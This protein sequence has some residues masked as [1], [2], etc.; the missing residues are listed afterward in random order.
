MKLFVQCYDE[1]YEL[2]VFLQYTV[3]HVKNMLRENEPNIDIMN[4]YLNEFK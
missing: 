3:E 2:E 4:L 1:T